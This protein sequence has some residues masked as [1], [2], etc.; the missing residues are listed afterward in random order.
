M[1]TKNYVVTI[2][3]NINNDEKNN[4]SYTYYIYSAL[5]RIHGYPYYVEY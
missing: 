1:V 2:V 5:F 4:Y 3:T